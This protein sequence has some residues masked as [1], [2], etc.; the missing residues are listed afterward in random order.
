ML[1]VDC[2]PI[3]HHSHSAKARILLDGCLVKLA[4]LSQRFDTV[5]STVRQ[6]HS[7][8]LSVLDIS[9]GVVTAEVDYILDE[10]LREVVDRVPH[11]MPNKQ[12]HHCHR[13]LS[14]PDH[15][16]VG[17]GINYC[18]LEHYELCPGGRQTEKGWT[19]CPTTDEEVEDAYKEGDSS[20]SSDTVTSKT[21]S[22]KSEINED[23]LIN[24]GKTDDIDPLNLENALSKQALTSLIL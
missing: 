5:L 10:I 6:G 17:S 23:L 22:P 2:T 20:S 11:I 4:S 15:K 18:S 24:K 14:H 16:G 19:G 1:E 13:P 7:K 8:S 21:N 9:C 12:C 3:R